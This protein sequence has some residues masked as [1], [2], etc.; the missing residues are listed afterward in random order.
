VKALVY[1][2]MREVRVETVDDPSIEKPQA[3]RRVRGG[4]LHDGGGAA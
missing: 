3:T 4:L 1:H 2:G